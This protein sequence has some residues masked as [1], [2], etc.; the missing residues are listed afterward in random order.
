MINRSQQQAGSEMGEVGELGS[1]IARPT[2]ENLLSPVSR[3][4]HWFRRSSQLSRPPYS[5]EP[6]IDAPT[7]LPEEGTTAPDQN[8]ANHRLVDAG[9]TMSRFNSIA[10]DEPENE[11]AEQP[12]PAGESQPRKRDRR[13]NFAKGALS[14]VKK[15]VRKLWPVREEKKQQEISSPLLLED[16]DQRGHHETG[17]METPS[18]A[19]SDQPSQQRNTATMAFDQGTGPSSPTSPFV[20]PLT[21]FLGSGVLITAEPEELAQQIGDTIRGVMSSAGE[22]GS[23]VGVAFEIPGDMLVSDAHRTE[24]G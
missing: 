13:K 23:F 5:G 21:D 22:P 17:V 18:P 11:M 6:D 10:R 3:T 4:T 24:T 19:P 16:G 9:T 2:R 7:P 1:I 20:A 8:Q 14:K 15:T 12:L